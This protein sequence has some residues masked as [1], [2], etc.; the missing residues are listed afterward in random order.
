MTQKSINS[1][2]KETSNVKISELQ[3]KLS[4]ALK[5][6]QT[7]TEKL[8]TL[9]NEKK[10]VEA[11]AEATSNRLK[12]DIAVL[13]KNAEKLQN[14]FE[15][16]R[17]SMKQYKEDQIKQLLSKDTELKEMKKRM[18]NLNDKKV[19]EIT[20]ETLKNELNAKQEEYEELTGKYE[21]LE[22]EHLVCCQ[23][24]LISAQNELRTLRE[25]YN[26]EQD[27]WIKEKL[28][29]EEKIKEL[30][31][32]LFSEDSHTKLELNKVKLMLEVKES[33]LEKLQKDKIIHVDQL[34]HMRKTND[35]LQKKLDDFDKV[36]KV[37]HNMVAD[38]SSLET[39]LRELKTK[40]HNEE[41]GR[42]VEIAALKLRYENHIATISEEQK[43]IQAQLARFKHERNTYKQ[44]LENQQK[45]ADIKIKKDI[46]TSSTSEPNDNEELQNQIAT[47]EQQISCMD[48]E[49]SE[50]RIES[51][52]LKAELVS[53]KSAWDIKL[54]EMTSRINELEE[55]RL[56]HSGRTKTA[57]LKTRMELSWQKEREEQNRLLQET[58]T[59]ARDLRQTL[60]EV[61]RERDKERFEMKRRIEQTKKNAEEEQEEMKNKLH[62]LQRDLLELRDAH[63]KLR[64]TNEKLRREKEL[65]RQNIRQNPFENEQK[66]INYILDLINDLSNSISHNDKSLPPVPKKQKIP[67][68]RESSA[69]MKN[70]SRESSVSKEDPKMQFQN[71]LQKLIDVG[72][73]IRA[74]QNTVNSLSFNRDSAKKAFVSRRPA[75]TESDKINDN[76]NTLQRRGSLYR[77]CISLE[78]TSQSVEAYEPIWRMDEDTDS[79]I[80]SFQSIDDI[81]CP[82]MN[83][84]YDQS[85]D[86]RLSG[87]STHSEMLPATYEKKK[88]KGFLD[89]LKKLTKSS[90]SIDDD[91]D[92]LAL[93][94]LSQVNAGSNN[95]TSKIIP[96]REFVP[97]KDL[98]GRITNLFKTSDYRNNS[99]ERFPSKQSNESIDGSTLSDMK[100]TESQTLPRRTVSSEAKTG[101]K[102]GVEANRGGATMPRL[103][104]KN[105]TSEKN[106]KI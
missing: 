49:L 12:I 52:R 25:T 24:E 81:Y 67:T 57:G 56:L 33:E 62:E 73:Q 16:E 104:Q 44:L 39:E 102:I 3:N 100:I 34:N 105:E 88:K 85:F 84:K 66:N 99:M 9:E 46:R 29:L 65:I 79:S 89:K 103:H 90:R 38:A 26:N 101:T 2:K 68:S 97:K 58:S 35:E 11:M 93:S 7:L 30:E 31:N 76:T 75:S 28:N 95:S 83:Y 61:E 98:K 23:K 80:V 91:T 60:F 6:I 72:R 48:D 21:L 96:N 47:L 8:K 86:S 71:T 41:K 27:H 53:E 40:L 14:D 18:L 45:N 94:C 10:T 13:K 64:T 78:Q 32:H 87:G 5:E 92:K 42:K 17:T 1:D 70:I 37:Q 69:E 55:E 77:K 22:D 50:A 106:E 19:D 74:N 4:K 20:L 63:A 43:D 36:I 59:L 82:K 54:S 51:S 15:A